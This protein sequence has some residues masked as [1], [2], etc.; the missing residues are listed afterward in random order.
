M[1]NLSA[2]GPP[3]A[4]GLSVAAANELQQNLAPMRF[5][6]VLHEVEALPCAQ[7]QRPRAHRN[8]QRNPGQH[9]LDVRRHV[10]RSFHGM[11]PRP[12]LGRHQAQRRGE[13]GLYVGVGVFLDDAPTQMGVWRGKLSG[14]ARLVDD[15]IRL[16]STGTYFQYDNVLRVRVLG[17]DASVGW[18]APGDWLGI[19]GKLSWQDARN[20]STSLGAPG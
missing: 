17:V 19:D 13:V 10:V 11:D 18:S 15:L 6:A 5:A 1:P 2:L 9:G 16:S 4:R 20:V 14:A 7:R 3:D 12:V 8:V